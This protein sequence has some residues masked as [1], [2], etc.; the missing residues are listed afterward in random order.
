MNKNLILLSGSLL[1]TLGLRAGADLIAP[2]PGQTT[3]P[4]KVLAPRLNANAPAAAQ[5]IAEQAPRAQAILNAYHNAEPVRGKRNLRIV[6]WTP[7][8]REP[9]PGYRERL[10]KI[11]FD[12]Q[13]FYAF[14]MNRNGF[15]PIAFN[16]EK[17]DDGLLKIYL[18]RAPKPRAEYSR[19]KSSGEIRQESQD[20]LKKAGIDGAQ[21][22]IIIFQNLVNWDAATRTMTGDYPYNGGGSTRSGSAV[23]VDSPALMLEGLLDVSEA[24]KVHNSEYGLIDLAR[25]NS[26]FIGG[27]AHELGHALSLPHDKGRA[28]E[29]AWGLSMMGAGNRTYGEDLRA[30]SVRESSGRG[31]FLTFADALRLASHPS[32]DGSLKGFDGQPNATFSEVK[33][34]TDGANLRYAA[35]V[36]AEPK[37]YGVIGYFDPEGGDDY[38]ARTFTA[39][40]DANGNFS[41]T[42]SS[43]DLVAGKGGELRVVALQVNG[44]TR[45]GSNGASYAYAVAPNGSVELAAWNTAQ[46]FLPL[47]AALKKR[48]RVAAQ[49]ALDTLI[50]DKAAPNLI[51]V[52]RV[53]VAALSQKIGPSPDTATDNSVWLSQSAPSSATVGWLQPSYDRLP[54]DGD[55]SVQLFQVGAQYF[56]HGIYAHAP[57]R[58]VYNLAGKWLR[59]SGVAGVQSGKS[60]RVGFTIRADDKEIWKSQPLEGSKSA[61]FDLDVRGVKTLELLTDD[62]GNGGN[63]DWGLWLDPKLTR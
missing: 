25:Y 57:A 48:D 55:T 58:H 17:A 39:V 11:M 42:A 6:Y 10:S 54:T 27:I 7:A 32:F 1:M 9:A 34:T 33:I 38:D 45:W 13:A 30:V 18:A 26:I 47:V 22:T 24:N 41:F 43:A 28:D 62:G 60:G 53:Q 16:L 5:V 61:S 36:T 49:R 44:A 46:Q 29:T 63:S 19:A 51:E 52:A 4:V 50:A 35:R 21:E 2:Q 20:A 37:V 40:P 23:Q 14:E 8:D 3:L 59:F 56:A 12:I 15:G 31:T